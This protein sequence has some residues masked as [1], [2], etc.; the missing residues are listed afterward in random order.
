MNDNSTVK[1][2]D[3]TDIDS[4]EKEKE[5]L[6]L[7]KMVKGAVGCEGVWGT[8]KR[9]CYAIIKNVDQGDGEKSHMCWKFPDTGINSWRIWHLLVLIAE[10]LR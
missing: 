10:Y 1:R 6:K 3:I 7:C 2:V 8:E 5:C 4:E 9:G